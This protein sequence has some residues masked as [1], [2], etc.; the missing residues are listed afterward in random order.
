VLVQY[1]VERWHRGVALSI[2]VLDLR[3]IGRGFDSH[4]RRLHSNYGQVVNTY[5]P[6]SP[7]SITWYRS[8]DGD[9]HRLGR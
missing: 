5:V 1:Y 6:L 3:S 7:S 8:K 9:V 4:Q 2:R